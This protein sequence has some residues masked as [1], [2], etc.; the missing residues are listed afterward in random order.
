MVALHGDLCMCVVSVKFLPVDEQ[1]SVTNECLPCALWFK[2]SRN[3][4]TLTI[5][6]LYSHKASG[7]RKSLSRLQGQR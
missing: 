4:L 6:G 2:S 3:L 7:G 1:L 5:F